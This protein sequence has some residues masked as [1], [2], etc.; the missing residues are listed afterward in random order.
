MEVR[1]ADPLR[2]A[3]RCAEIYTPYVTDHVASF[4]QE[5]PDEA[6]MARR[7]TETA[8]THPWLVCERGGRV[9]GFAYGC[10][11]R[12]RHAYRWAADVSVYVDS[13]HHGT[14]VGRALYSDL[15]ERL[16]EQGLYTVCAG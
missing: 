5:A 2:D 15:L 1:S 12:T 16:R 11:H 14:G 4:E 8:R 9:A 10:P 3:A 7:I 6:E 13:E